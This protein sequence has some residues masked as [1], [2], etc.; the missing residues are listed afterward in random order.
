MGGNHSQVSLAHPVLYLPMGIQVTRCQVRIALRAADPLKESLLV[1]ENLSCH[2]ED[3]GL[4]V[5]S[6][7][8]EAGLAHQLDYYETSGGEYDNIG[9][10]SYGRRR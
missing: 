7:Y 5:V 4:R 3:V 9:A 6:P 10:T 8:C 2:T 1:S